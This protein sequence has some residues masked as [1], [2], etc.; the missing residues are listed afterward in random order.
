VWERVTIA[1]FYQELVIVPLIV[2]VIFVN[3]WGAGLNTKRAKEWAKT[4]FPLLEEEYAAVGYAGSIGQKDLGKVIAQ[5]RSVPASLLK[6]KSKNEY[7]TYATGRQNVAWLDVKITLYKRYNPFLLL[8]EYVLTF[9]FDMG[10][11]PTERLEA[12]AYCFDGKEKALVPS[13]NLGPGNKDSTYDGFVWAIVHKDR[14]KTLREDRYDVSLTST[15]D[16]P[17]LPTWVT[18]MSESALIT[19]ALLT[20]ELIKAV[21]DAGEDLE[22]LIVTDQPVDAPKK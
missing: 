4:Y 22:A 18:V 7:V 14:M 11:P 13:Q 9:L 3:L 2:L 19:E 1:D 6:E 21:N 17:S 10:A 5:S 16:H 20:P 8:A 15:K 12:T